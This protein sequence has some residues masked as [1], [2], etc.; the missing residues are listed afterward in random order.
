[1]TQ[2]YIRLEKKQTNKNPQRER[3]GLIPTTA[4]IAH[5]IYHME[6]FFYL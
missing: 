4:N 1:M 3:H 2:I 5:N 6:F